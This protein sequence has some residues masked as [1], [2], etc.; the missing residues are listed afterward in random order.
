MLIKKHRAYKSRQKQDEGHFEPAN[1]IKSYTEI[2]EIDD[3]NI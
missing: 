1:Y 3:T 2:E